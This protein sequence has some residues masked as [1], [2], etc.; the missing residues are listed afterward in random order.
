MLFDHLTN[1]LRVLQVK[2]CVDFVKNIQGCW[3]ELEQSKH[4]T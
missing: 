3:L 1:V 2:G 4:E